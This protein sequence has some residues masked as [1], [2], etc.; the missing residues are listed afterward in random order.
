MKINKIIVLIL[1]MTFVMV[2]TVY[3]ENEVEVTIPEFGI[4]IGAEE[5]DNVHNEFPLIL[6]NDITYFPM[7]WNFSRALGLSSNWNSGTGLSIAETS[8]TEELVQDKSVTNDLSRTYTATIAEFGINLNGNTINNSEEEYPILLFRDVTYF[9]LTWKFTVDEFGWDSKF[10]P[11][12]GL[13]IVNNKIQTTVNIDNSSNNNTTVTGVSDSSVVVNNNNIDSSVNDSNNVY[14]DYSTNITNN[15]DNSV[16]LD[17]DAKLDALLEELQKLKDTS[18]ADGTLLIS[19]ILKDTDTG[20][21]ING[22]TVYINNMPVG[23]SDVTGLAEIEVYKYAEYSIKINHDNYYSVTFNSAYNDSRII[24][25]TLRSNLNSN[26]I[27]LGVDEIVLR[28]VESQIIDGRIVDNIDFDFEKDDQLVG[29]WQA[30]QFV[31]MP[32]DFYANEDN[33]SYT[34]YLKEMEFYDRGR[35]SFAWTWTNGL[36]LHSGDKTASRYFFAEVNGE[37]YLFFEW[38]SGDYVFRGQEPKYYV[39]KRVTTLD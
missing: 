16:N 3:A 11:S 22:A 29:K 30:I 25:L 15:I 21:P 37:E 36:I 7:T 33:F 13:S 27:K 6:Y 39:L 26:T 8:E 28:E 10:D 32:I 9:P 1:L 20:N 35:T 5:I 12:K 2:N 24:N 31:E 38:K 14:N 19:Y 4:N 18:V 23:V 34:L 17:T